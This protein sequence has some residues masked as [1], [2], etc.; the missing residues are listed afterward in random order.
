MI[1]MSDVKK[2]ICD[3]ALS[4]VNGARRQAY[5]G[6]EENFGRIAKLWTDHLFNLDV[7]ATGCEI[8]PRDVGLLMILM[9]VARLA[10]SP[11]H[12]DSVVDLVGYALTYAEMMIEPQAEQPVPRDASTMPDAPI[13]P[14]VMW[15]YS[16]TI[17]RS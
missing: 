3:E 1:S 17:K 4:I 10:E 15:P 14:K 12:R 13:V 2:E 7:L 16:H 9:K 6:P 5:G 11:R 8:K